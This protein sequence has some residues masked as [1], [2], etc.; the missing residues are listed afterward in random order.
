[1]LP[2]PSSR[3]ADH[4]EAIARLT[5]NNPPARFGTTARRLVQVFCGDYLK[6]EPLDEQVLLVIGNGNQTEPVL[7][8]DVQIT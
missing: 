2:E 8:K 7:R 3:R 6:A 4:L 1:M 5:E